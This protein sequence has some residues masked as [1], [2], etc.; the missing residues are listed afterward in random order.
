MVLRS[1]WTSAIGAFFA[2]FLSVSCL[3]PAVNL[4][5]SSVAWAQTVS[6]IVVEG[7]QR[8][9]DETVR[10]YLVLQPGSAYSAA[11]ADESL[12]NLFDTGLFSDVDISLRGRTVYVIVVE[13]P[14]INRVSFEGNRRIK[15]AVLEA[16]VQLGPRSVYSRAK[17]QADTQRILNIYRRTGRFGA[18]VEPKIIELPQNRVDLVFEI[19][20]AKKTGVRRISFIGNRAFGEGTL[21]EVI[22]T[23]QSNFLSF[24]KTSDIYDPERIE[25]D[26]ELLRRHYL[27]NGYADFRVVSAVADYDQDGNAFF[28]TF[29]LDEGPQY[30]FGDV[31]I[32]SEIPDIDPNLLR[33]VVRTRPGDVYN[34][35][36]VEKTL[37]A[38][39]IEVA[40][41]GY[42]FVRVRPSGERDPDTQTISIVYVIE[43]G[44]RVY[45]ER[46]N[47]IGNTR[48]LDRVI[49]REFDLEEGDPYN[50][51]LVQRAERKLNAL[52]YFQTVRISQAPGS[53]PDRIVL[54]VE[55]EEQPTG[56]LSI[57]AG[58]STSEGIIGDVS[59]SERNLL[60][61][62]QNVRLA[63]GLSAEKRT[64]D[65]SFTEPWFLDRRLSFGF[66]LFYREVDL[67]DE[68]SYS[69]EQRGGSLRLGFL[70]A[71]DLGVQTRYTIKQEDITIGAGLKPSYDCDG[72]GVF[73]E[74]DCSPGGL[75]V[76]DGVLD[77]IGM[78]AGDIRAALAGGVTVVPTGVSPYIL[79]TEG[80][81][82]TSSVGFTL[83][84]NKLDFP[85]DPKN[86]HF[87]QIGTDVAGL[88]GDSNY[89]AVTA[90]ARTYREVFPDIIV[91]GRLQGGFMSSIDGGDV[92]IN[93][94]FF[95]GPEIVR[96]FASSGIGPRA[97]RNFAGPDGVLNTADDVVSFRDALG[98]TAYWGA[99]AEVRFPIW[100]LPR[101][102]GFTGAVFADAGSLFNVGDLG[103]LPTMTDATSAGTAVAWSVQ[104]EAAV[105]ASA[106]FSV[107]WKSPFGP[108][109]A[110]FA[111][112]LAEQDYDDTQFF[113]FS[114]G[115]R[116]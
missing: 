58:Y 7:N 79:A 26:Q 103:N 41:S 109:R 14:V 49:R 73:A 69:T 44:P 114:G 63:V 100:G 75:A 59:I 102:L 110:D 22:T 6:G 70:L 88:G 21:R 101:S 67:E 86:G 92:L 65:F 2:V 51:V 24:I 4:G 99:S 45:V 112:P 50:G 40:S 47:I 12:K 39:T 23:S 108:L 8:V 87:F 29:T 113:R 48:T 33:S 111:W 116:F 78:D 9:E 17:V 81:T 66:D 43:E 25:A 98:G 5:F 32:E 13:N 77:Q 10:S 89:A 74:D 34:A 115:T 62:G 15:D 95:R 106:G 104:D 84:W 68:S 30:R 37:E 82:T 27:K 1:R 42:A 54:N 72:D 76:A 38:L 71:E 55:V 18:R 53:T 93:D 57:G 83:T 91:L 60:G 61:R 20:E 3:P 31:E 80:E 52:G 97:Q 90:S 19:S 94:S 96:G 107:L 16:E 28:I 35:E 56:E 85:N 64:F 105:R 11:R 46:I 36:L